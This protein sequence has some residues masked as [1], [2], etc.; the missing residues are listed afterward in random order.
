MH[1]PVRT[2][3]AALTAAA[4]AL[5]AMACGGNGSGTTGEAAL[6]PVTLILDWT[7]NTNHSGFYVARAAGWYRDAGLDVTIVEPDE[8][9][10]LPQLSAGNADFAVSVA[11][12]LL[13]ARAQGV[14]AVS[15]AAII[16]H[17]TSSLVIPA[18]R[19][20]TRPR[21][22]EGKTY[23]GFGGELERALVDTL[24]RCDGGDPAKV[25][26]VEVGNVD[27]RVGL[28]RGDYDAVW[29]FD[30][31]DAIRLRDLEGMAITT[32]PFYGGGA[33]ADCLPD[34][35]TPLL[36]TTESRIAEDPELV[37]DFVAA[38][39]KG[40]EQARTDPEAAARDLLAAAPELDAELVGR[41]A[42]YL[43]TRYAEP[44]RPWG[45]QSPEVW[46]T[47]A[48]FLTEAGLL[49]GSIDTDAAFTN[50]FL[51]AGEAGAGEGGTTGDGGEEAP[52]TTRTP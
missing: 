39:A 41:S 23:G 8:S 49:E 21:D 26:F 11:E 14:P 19:G 30:G 6:R 42:E 12:Q 5:V 34:W 46:S 32:I 37:T 52:P 38:T 13:P 22:L 25:G 7:P 9:G 33:G 29:V 50:A 31:W 20:V 43:S 3:L 1:R 36:A 51:P 18:D 10:A 15:V 28:D 2:A 4:L 45:L 44:G 40:F 27:Y 47:F 48:G 16:G 35:Y 17:N 24:V